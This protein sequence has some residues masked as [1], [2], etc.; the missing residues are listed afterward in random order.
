[1]NERDTLCD[2]QCHGPH[3]TLANP[4]TLSSQNQLQPQKGQNVT[5]PT[6]IIPEQKW[7]TTVNEHDTYHITSNRGRRRMAGSAASIRGYTVTNLQL[8]AWLSLFKL[9]EP[10]RPSAADWSLHNLQ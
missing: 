7:Q 5:F 3:F 4:A 10:C 6:L 8:P 2:L 1:M 9:W